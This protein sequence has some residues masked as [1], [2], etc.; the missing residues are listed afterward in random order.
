MK[1]VYFTGLPGGGKTIGM[2]Y[3]TKIDHE[4]GRQTYLNCDTFFPPVPNNPYM[5]V[6]ITLADLV[7]TLYSLDNPNIVPKI[8]ADQ[9]PKTIALDEVHTMWNAYRY[10][11]QDALDLGFF[12]DQH[13]KIQADIYYTSQHERQIPPQLRNVTT[14]ICYCESV[15]PGETDNPVGFIYTFTS[16]WS[17]D[18]AEIKIPITEMIP[19]FPLYRTYQRIKPVV[20]R[21]KKN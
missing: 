10:N 8:K 19:I 16:R 3:F 1:I 13:R 18:V 11:S 21:G 12:V 5:P 2:I 15:P 9:W 20:N 14:H 7:E 6:K 17:K 4:S